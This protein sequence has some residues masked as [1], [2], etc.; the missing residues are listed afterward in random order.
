MNLTITRGIENNKF[1][2][3]VAFKEYG[4]VGMT[5]EDEM[6]LLQNYPIVLTYGD[7]TFSDKF[8][9]VAGNVE[10]DSS[11]GETVT[12]ILSERKTPVTEA[13]QVKYEVNAN[14]I[15][16]SEIGT[17]LTTKELVAQAKCILFEMKI[18]DRISALLA[19]A[20]TKN[21]SFEID[22]PIDVI[23]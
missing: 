15:L 16:D 13:F 10:Q 5:A 14:Q 1:T 23:V 12:L 3:L 11:L 4:G 17:L 19:I 6:A 22:S 2:T 9:V 20:K 21:S 7:I 8:N 18:K